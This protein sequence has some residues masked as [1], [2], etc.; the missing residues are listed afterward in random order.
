MT[1]NDR[2]LS[3]SF[4]RTNNDNCNNIINPNDS[5]RG[6]RNISLAVILHDGNPNISANHNHNHSK[7]IR[8]C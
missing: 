2:R 3:R 1:R 5:N 4:R 7:H 6:H 8:R